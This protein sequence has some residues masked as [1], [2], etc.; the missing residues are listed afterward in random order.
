MIGLLARRPR[1]RS[2]QASAGQSAVSS[3]TA[4]RGRYAYDAAVGSDRALEP[5]VLQIPRR[6]PIVAVSFFAFFAFLLWMAGLSTSDGARVR[7]LIPAAL[8]TLVVVVA[9]ISWVGVGAAG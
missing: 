1:P 4:C 3:G 7:L 8:L 2:R 6:T 5:I 9:L